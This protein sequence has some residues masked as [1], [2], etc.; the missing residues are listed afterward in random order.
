[1]ANEVHGNQTTFSWGGNT[2]ASITNIG[3]VEITAGKLD[4]TTL[5]STMKTYM[6]DL[7]ETS[8]I[9]ISGFMDLTDS[10]GQI[11]ML[12]DIAARTQREVII[13]LPDSAAT[14]TFDAFLTSWKQGEFI[15]GVIPFTGTIAAAEAP[16]LTQTAVTGMSAIGFSNDDLIMPTFAIGR[17]GIT[18]PYNVNI[19]ALETATVI[20]PVDATSGEVITITTDGGSSQVVP[21]GTASAACTLDVDDVTQ[22]VVTIT[23]SGYTSKAYYFNCAVLAA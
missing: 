10:T 11:Q 19:T 2:V 15:N 6:Q 22:I 23:K 16:T 3:G 7:A 1:M 13:T 18:N 9:P 17:Y 4:I 14:W 8:D 5:E 21:T 20:T 12:T